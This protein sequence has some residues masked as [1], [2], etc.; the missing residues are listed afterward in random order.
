MAGGIGLSWQVPAIADWV[1]RLTGN[2]FLDPSV[3]PITEVP[4]L[5]VWSDVWMI[6]IMAF[7]LTV[8]ATLYPAWQ[9]SRVCPSEA[10]RYE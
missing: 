1:E 8:L 9:A 6:G 3:Y 5:L 10:L 2:R 4:S 7:V